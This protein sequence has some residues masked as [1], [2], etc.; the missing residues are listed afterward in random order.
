MGAH[1]GKNN[2]SKRHCTKSLKYGFDKDISYYVR[3]LTSF[4]H[5][6][7]TLFIHSLQ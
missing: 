6:S 1:N 2:G 7:E 3:A 4:N 5:V